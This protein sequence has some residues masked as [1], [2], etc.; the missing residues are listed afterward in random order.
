M[1]QR[2]A[3]LVRRG[4]VGARPDVTCADDCAAA[5]EPCGSMCTSMARLCVCMLSFAGDEV[6]VCVQQVGQL[7]Q[8]V[9]M[10]HLEGGRRSVSVAC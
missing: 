6:S 2:A 1:T 3:S 7:H 4:C 9:Y 5:Y 8:H 10:P